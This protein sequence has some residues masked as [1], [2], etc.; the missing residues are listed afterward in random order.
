MMTAGRMVPVP[1]CP[2]S[3]S[4]IPFQIPGD[5]PPP[6]SA[7]T[8]KN[9]NIPV[10]LNPNAGYQHAETPASQAQFDG[11][12]APPAPPLSCLPGQHILKT[13]NQSIGSIQRAAASGQE[14]IDTEKVITMINP[15]SA[16]L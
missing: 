9:Q 15:G 5:Q 2:T 4:L 16:P 6:R 12:Q 11:N 14:R 1:R 13:Q 3:Q 7:L 8:G 10:G